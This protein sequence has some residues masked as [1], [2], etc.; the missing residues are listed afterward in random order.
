VKYLIDGNKIAGGNVKEQL[1]LAYLINPPAFTILLRAQGHEIKDLNDLDALVDAVKAKEKRVDFIRIINLV[2]VNSKILR[3][4][5]SN[6]K[7]V[8]V[9]HVNPKHINTRH[10]VNALMQ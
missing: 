1:R 9:R 10:D 4:A 8:G 6:I 7:L 5:A 3:G 2:P